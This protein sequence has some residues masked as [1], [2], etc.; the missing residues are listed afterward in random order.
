MAGAAIGLAQGT[1]VGYGAN[2]IITTLAFNGAL[3]GLAATTTASH[4]IVFG[5]G[6]G[7]VIGTGRP[8][9]IPIQVIVFAVVVVLGIIAS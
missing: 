7:N 1:L 8:A 2:P 6:T 4:S 9:G 3:F 5:N